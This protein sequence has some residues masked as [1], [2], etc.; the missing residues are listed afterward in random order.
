MQL[1]EYNLHDLFPHTCNTIDCKQNVQYTRFKVNTQKTF[2][3]LPC[4]SLCITAFQ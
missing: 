4:R 3:L 2:P 1:T